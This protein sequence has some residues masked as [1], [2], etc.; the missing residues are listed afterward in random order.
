MAS[1]ITLSPI[2]TFATGIFDESAAEI[3]AFDPISQSLFVTNG[4]SDAIDILDLSDPTAPTLID[5]IDLEPFGGGPNSVTVSNGIV[6]VAVENEDDT[7]P[8]EVVFFDTDGVFLNSVT[9][10]VLPDALAF[11]PDGSRI[12]VANEGEAVGDDDDFLLADPEGSISIIDLS[13]GVE[14]AT[15]ATADFSAFVGLEDELRA[16]GIRIFPGRTA[17][18]DFEPEFPTVSPDGTT[19]FVTLQENNAIAVV[20]IASAT[21]TD[22]LPLGTTDFSVAPNGLDPSDVDGVINIAN[23]PV[24]GLLQPD[25]I[26]AFEVD[27]E[28]FFISANEGDNRDDIVDL[29]DVAPIG[30][31]DLDPDAFPD[32]ATLQLPEL[33]GNLEGSLIDG[34]LDGD[35]DFDQLFA[36]G[37]RSFSIFSASGEQVFDSG[38]FFEELT[39]AEFPDNFNSDNDENSFDTESD[40]AGPEP[41]GAA[42]GIVG[43]DTFAFIGLESIGGIVTFNVS[44]PSSPEFVDFINNR[45]FSGDPEAGTALDLGPE[46]LV[47]ISAEDSPNSQPLLVVAN[48]VSGT[49]TVFEIT[50]EIT[51]TAGDDLL[52]GTISDDVIVGLAGNDTLLGLGGDDTLQSGVGVDVVDGGVGIDT[53]DFSDIP[54]AVDAD[55]GDGIA[56]YIN[57]AGVL[58]IDELVDIENLVGNDFD[59]ELVGDAGTNVLSGA[60]GADTLAGE[61]GDDILFGEDG[62]DILRGD[63]NDSSPGGPIGGDDTIFGGDG[64]DAIGG[65]GGA[66]LL[67]GELGDDLIFGDDGDDTLIGGLGDDILTGDDFSGGAGSDTFVLGIDEGTDTITDFEIGTD[68]IGLGEGLSFGA[69]SIEQDG[70]DALIGFGGETLAIVNSVL[71]TSLTEAVFTVF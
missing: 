3:P 30:E 58:I 12:V 66:D 34:D 48:E 50:P 67:L 2:G 23:F 65:K 4:D 56:A 8:G 47:F 64:D 52:E 40:E 5:S 7:A 1:S 39:A 35:G 20:D 15:V 10:G 45:D 28:T 59:N 43:D 18:E 69:L 42:V 55:L 19:A 36:F 27:G 51:G 33:L 68:F 57:G 25:A 70:S 62:A 49:T 60:D 31:F 38:A 44:D 22:L 11:T 9:V 14:S 26:A 71:A 24:F 41:E 29:T 46:G 54:F 32:A 21:V 63:L 17:A 53:A 61:L 13:D 37:A 6:A 16:E